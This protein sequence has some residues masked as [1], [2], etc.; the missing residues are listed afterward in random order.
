[1][2]KYAEGTTVEPPTIEYVR[3]LDAPATRGKTWHISPDTPLG[4]RIRFECS[5]DTER[6]GSGIETTRDPIRKPDKVCKNCL[7][8]RKVIDPG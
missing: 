5:P 4:L 7:A 6:V 3:R 2:S 8:A 1:M